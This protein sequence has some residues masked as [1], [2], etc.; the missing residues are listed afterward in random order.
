M[1]DSREASLLKQ[2]LQ[3]CLAPFRGEVALGQSRAQ[4]NDAHRQDIGFSQTDR[5]HLGVRLLVNAGSVVLA[6]RSSRVVD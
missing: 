5:N 3:L 2:C 4:V 1:E 6:I